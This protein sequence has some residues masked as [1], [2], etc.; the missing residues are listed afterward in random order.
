M[1]I[2]IYV[3]DELSFDAHHRKA[4]RI[5]RIQAHYQFGD[6]KDD[7]GITPFPIVGALLKEYPDIESGVS[8]FQL[9]STTLEYNGQKFTA[10]D[11]YNADTSTFRTFDFTFTHGGADALDQPD[12][13]VIMQDMAT[14]M[15]GAEDPIG[16]LVTRN[17]RTL[18]VAGVIDQKAENTHIPMGVF[19]SRLGMPPQAKDQLD[20][21]WGQNSCFNYL[22][23]APGVDEHAFQDKMDAFVTKYI[24]PQWGGADFQG[25]HPLQP[26]A[27]A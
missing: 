9:G 23:L 18:K 16:K 24:I 25:Q 5:F 17:G 2:Y 19:M 21:S 4:D 10:T 26:G 14:R 15:F 11:G 8:L 1:L 3:Q 7:F 20:Q 6:T 22:V 12:N 27:L 13:I